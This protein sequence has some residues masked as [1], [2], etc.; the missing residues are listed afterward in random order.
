MSSTTR[1]K[2]DNF[3]E[4]VQEIL[5][6]YEEGGLTKF[7]EGIR[8]L[9]N[10]TKA[11]VKNAAHSPHGD[12]RSHIAV[13]YES[14]NIGATSIVYVKA[15]KYRIAHLLEKGHQIVYYGHRT[16]RRSREFPHF[17][18]GQEYVDANWSKIV[19]DA[20]ARGS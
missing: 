8:E 3:P 19:E 9:G 15:P 4:K 2:I 12:Y 14:G 18:V 17:S 10:K 5:K 11:I 1:C 20:Y 6:D 13:K 16:G 7:K